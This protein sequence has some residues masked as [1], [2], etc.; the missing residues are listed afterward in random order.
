MNAGYFFYKEYYRSAFIEEDSNLKHFDPRK[1]LE[2]NNAENKEKNKTIS[3]NNLSV[4][5]SKN[6]ELKDYKPEQSVIDILKLG[7][8]SFLRER[9]TVSLETIYPGLVLG[10]GYNH[11]T[12]FEG[13][14]KL[15]FFF[16]YTTGL[17]IIPGS[18][19]KGKLRSVF[20]WYSN[21]KV[22]EKDEKALYI[23]NTLSSYDSSH[24]VSIKEEDFYSDQNIKTKEK[25]HHVITLLESQIFDGI[26]IKKSSDSEKEYLSIYKRD[27]FHDAI[28][29]A[30]NSKGF[31]FDNDYITPHINRSHPELS[32]FTNP[33]PLQFFK[34]I[35]KVQ[36]LFQFDLK[37][38]EID[39]IKISSKLKCD[40]FK[41][42]LIDFG[43]GAKT[44][45]GYGQFT[46]CRPIIIPPPD[47]IVPPSPDLVLIKG[48]KTSGIVDKQ[49]SGYNF[50][51]FVY[52]KKECIIKKKTE[53]NPDLKVGDPVNIEFTNPYSKDNP[54]MK[55]RKA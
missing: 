34:V 26:D 54:N 44:N 40:L 7:D 37:E 23:W 38:T 15:G 11:E 39:G 46:S 21:T 53:K 51:K 12:G 19:V 50:Y 27:T 42:I 43:I 18:S 10:T 32:P 52:Q 49:L 9:Q 33:I 5:E 2:R 29:V 1:F 48:V 14:H 30:P 28:F 3:I 22:T 25:V 8:D 41:Q 4:F 47:D 13:E 35:P 31:I 6:K 55:V 24:F 16:D 45:V 36:F 20:P 17:P